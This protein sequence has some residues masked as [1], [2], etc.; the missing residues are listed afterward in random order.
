M[1]STA[2]AAGAG[3]SQTAPTPPSTKRP[4]RAIKVN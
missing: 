4:S 2:G 3:A 1:P